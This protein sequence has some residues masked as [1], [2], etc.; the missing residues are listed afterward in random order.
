MR[1]REF[2]AEEEAVIQQLIE[3]RLMNCPGG[4][5]NVGVLVANSHVVLEANRRM[6]VLEEEKKKE[7]DLKKKAGEENTLQNAVS[8][9]NKW[10]LD[11]KPIDSK[12]NG[13]K[14]SKDDAKAIVR[15]LLPKSLPSGLCQVVRR[16][17]WQN[18]M[19]P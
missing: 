7:H 2:P 16:Y 4:L 9:Y 14:L 18:N 15:V 5:F 1:K 13:P 11:G 17:Y 8:V 10:V 3:K 19:G 12:N 6:A